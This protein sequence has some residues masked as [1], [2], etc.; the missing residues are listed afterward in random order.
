MLF[1]CSEMAIGKE[2][3]YYF[4]RGIRVCKRWLCFDNFLADMGRRPVGTTLDRWSN[5]NGNYTPGNVRWADKYE[6]NRNTRGNRVVMFRGRS[7]TVT[8]WANE[9]GCNPQTVFQRLRK[10]S[11]ARA[12]SVDVAPRNEPVLF[13]GRGQS[14]AAWARELGIHPAIIGSRLRRGWSVERALTEII[15]HRDLFSAKAAK[16]NGVP[17]ATF[18]T[19]KKRG[20]SAEQA[21]Q[22]RGRRERRGEQ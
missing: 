21:V 9:L 13:N 19:R 6:Q 15:V 3:K 22:R 5:K 20:W 16:A 1:R 17:V 11:P 8:E 7:Q 2:R 10:W 12:V 18:H 14:V 4:D